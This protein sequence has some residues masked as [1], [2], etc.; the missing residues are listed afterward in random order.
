MNAT[1]LKMSLIAL[2]AVLLAF[3]S[4][5]FGRAQSTAGSSYS[6]QPQGNSGGVWVLDRRAGKLRLC[7]PPLHINDT[8]DCSEWKSL[9]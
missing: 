8:P 4:A 9:P 2:A 3:S 5:G 6:I 7:T 1:Y